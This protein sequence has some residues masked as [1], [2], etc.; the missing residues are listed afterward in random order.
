MHDEMKKTQKIFLH[1]LLGMSIGAL[2]GFVFFYSLDRTKGWNPYG[3][4]FIATFI[5]TVIGGFSGLFVSNW[6]NKKSLRNHNAAD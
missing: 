1:V 4:W 2:I 5:F 3:W 6:I